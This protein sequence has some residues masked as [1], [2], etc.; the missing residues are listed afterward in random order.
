MHTCFFSRIMSECLFLA[1]GNTSTLNK[2]KKMKTYFHL[3][4]PDVNA[5]KFNSNHLKYTT[6]V[7]KK[8]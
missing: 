7:N 6:N 5:F 3:L 8:V 2:T 1:K 4:H